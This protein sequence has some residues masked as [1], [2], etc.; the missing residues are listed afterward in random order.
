MPFPRRRP[1]RAA[2]A[3]LF[4]PLLLS[5]GA[6]PQAACAANA[7]AAAAQPAATDNAAFTAWA[8]KFAAESVRMDPQLATRTQ[9][10][11]GTQQDALDRELTPLTTAQRAKHAKHNRE[12]V[13][14]LKQWRA[15]K[16][17]DAQRVSAAVMLWALES[18]VAGEPFEDHRFVFNQMS[19]AHVSLVQFMTQV[20]PLRRAADVPAYLARLGQVPVRID[21][22]AYG[23]SGIPQALR[24]KHWI[25][26][27]DG[28]ANETV[29][30]HFV[31]TVRTVRARRARGA[32]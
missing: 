11:A 2:V 18:E 32:A 9:Y 23:E 3:T 4:V 5:V 25:E 12:G 29:V 7:A 30:Q 8:D 6:F 22:V 15:A 16:L 31:Q 19:G 21:D 1:M 27:P 28:E 14:R 17:G 26:M 13:A 20:Q 10:F 24:E